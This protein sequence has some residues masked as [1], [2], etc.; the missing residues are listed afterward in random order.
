MAR[1]VSEKWSAPTGNRNSSFEVS[2][3][4]GCQDTRNPWNYESSFYVSYFSAAAY[5]FL[6][7]PLFLLF[8]ARL[9]RQLLVGGHWHHVCARFVY[10][11]G[12]RFT[13]NYVRIGDYS[14]RCSAGKRFRIRFKE[15]DKREKDPQ[16]FPLAYS[17]PLLIVKRKREKKAIEPNRSWRRL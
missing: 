7:S 3:R 12:N 8:C 14:A 2:T 11:T 10:R 15:P 17:S 13:F 9:T 4:K 5:L 1:V 6:L 16:H